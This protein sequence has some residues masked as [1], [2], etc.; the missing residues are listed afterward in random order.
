MAVARGGGDQVAEGVLKLVADTQGIL[1]LHE[2]RVGL[3][4]A[5]QRVIPSEVPSKAAGRA[6]APS[7]AARANNRSITSTRPV[8]QRARR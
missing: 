6:D 3:L 2:F 5:L 1:D 7:V 8:S 4:D